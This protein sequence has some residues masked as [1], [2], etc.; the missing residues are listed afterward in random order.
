MCAFFYQ[1]TIKVIALFFLGPPHLTRYT[2]HCSVISFS[3]ERKT[4]G[5]VEGPCRPQSHLK[6][7]H[8]GL[9]PRRG[10]CW[11]ERK[12]IRSSLMNGH[13]F[14]LQANWQKETEINELVAEPAVFSAQSR[15]RWGPFCWPR[16]SHKPR[17][18]PEPWHLAPWTAWRARPVPMSSTD[19]AIWWV[20]YTLG[21]IFDAFCWRIWRRTR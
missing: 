3:S 1:H 12:K 15:S 11:K 13:W 9:S 2:W 17:T 21:L 4:N 18:Q 19:V 5:K 10:S 7:P 6:K 20:G 14:A 16:L 8:M